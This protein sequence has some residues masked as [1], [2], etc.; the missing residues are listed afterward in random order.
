M[1][2]EDT[3]GWGR[4]INWIWMGS[5]TCMES[6]LTVEQEAAQAAGPERRLSSQGFVNGVLALTSLPVLESAPGY[7]VAALGA[8]CSH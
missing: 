2:D 5:S 4:G 3:I 8:S 6:S 1:L 7:K